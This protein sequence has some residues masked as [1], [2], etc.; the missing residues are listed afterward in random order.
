[1]ITDESS[2]CFLTQLTLPECVVRWHLCMITV[3][4][5]QLVRA[6]KHQEMLLPVSY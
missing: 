4:L 3:S 2:P 6:L 1:M 5:M